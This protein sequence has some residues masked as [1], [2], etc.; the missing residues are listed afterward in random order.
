MSKVF[1]AKLK[2]DSSA[3]GDVWG[4]QQLFNTY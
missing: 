4:H 1:E 2:V 3:K